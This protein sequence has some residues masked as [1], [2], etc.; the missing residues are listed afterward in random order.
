[1]A[2]KC[3]MCS[4]PIDRTSGSFPCDCL[5]VRDSL[6]GPIAAGW[7]ADPHRID[8]DEHGR[9][10]AALDVLDLAEAI[11][12]ERARRDRGGE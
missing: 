2:D 9:E 10:C 11:V 6:L 12:A 4:A 1:M 5:A 7:V 8:L 3:R